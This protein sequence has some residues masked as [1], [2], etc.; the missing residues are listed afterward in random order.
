MR[1]P[2]DDLPSLVALKQQREESE[3]AAQKLLDSSSRISPV[4]ASVEPAH[5]SPAKRGF[6]PLGSFAEEDEASESSDEESLPQSPRIAPVH[7]F[8]P[9]EISHLLSRGR[10]FVPLPAVEEDGSDAERGSF[11]VSSEGS[12]SDFELSSDA[13]EGGPSPTVEGAEASSVTTDRR[14]SCIVS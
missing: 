8:A 2:F 9:V 3:A 4:H 11:V 10:G 12:D 6:T 7:N 14:N 1:N 5:Q 13:E